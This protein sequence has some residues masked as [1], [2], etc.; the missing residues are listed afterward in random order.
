M[1]STIMQPNDTLLMQQVN[2]TVVPP[3]TPLLNATSILMGQKSTDQLMAQ[4][5]DQARIKRA[6][7]FL[8]DPQA[9]V[10]LSGFGDDGHCQVIKR[11]LNSAGALCVNSIN[12]STTHIVVGDR[13]LDMDHKRVLKQLNFSPH[14]VGLQ[15]IVES[16]QMSRPV[17]ESGQ[18]TSTLFSFV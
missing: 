14:L 6:G 8:D 7:A 13:G 4:L 17:P 10:V 12:R 18:V 1:C 9:K 3:G 16:M 2:E 15:W 5:T 11:V